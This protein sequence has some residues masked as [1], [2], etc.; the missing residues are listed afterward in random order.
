MRESKIQRHLIVGIATLNGCAEKFTSPGKR[1][2]PDLLVTWGWQ[3]SNAI[4]WSDGCAPM[5]EFIETKAPG[6]KPTPGQLRDHTRRRAMGFEVHV[7]GSIEQAEE[8][9]RMRGKKP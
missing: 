1:F 7:I 3:N 4:E 5:T 9:L 6:G 8:Y 2:V